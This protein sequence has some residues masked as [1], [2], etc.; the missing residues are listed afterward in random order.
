MP[1]RWMSSLLALA[2]LLASAGSDNAEQTAEENKQAPAAD[3]PKQ[4]EPPDR[5]EVERLVRRLGS[6]SFADREEVMKELRRL[7]KPALEAL[8]NAAAASDDKEVRRRAAD[9]LTQLLEPPYEK[10]YKEGVRLLEKKDYRKAVT[11]L[12]QAAEM[13]ENDPTIPRATQGRS[14]QPFLAEIYLRLARAYRGLE[15]YE[16]AGR[17]YHGA[18][19]NYN[20]EKREQIERECKAMIDTL[21]AEWEKGVTAKIAKDAS[22]KAVVGKY[23]LV[24][25]HTR[26]FA[27]GNYFKSAY[28]FVYETSDE[29]KHFNNV[30]I[31]FDNGPGN[32]TFNI[33]MTTDQRN[34]VVDLGEIDFTK[35]P[36][37]KKVDPDSDN[38]WMPSRCKVV[39]GHIYLERVRD[40][41]G[42]KFY[43]V[44]KV[45]AAD[46]D[47]RYMAFVWRRLPGG[48][49]VK[50]Q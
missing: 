10:R 26:R 33:N 8:R 28:S 25:L 11:E 7:G 39:E 18:L 21:L 6:D 17:A 13:Y 20:D 23:P 37:P 2:L 40:D 12:K 22:L 49:V 15:E 32:N 46:K 31:L 16:E 42:N 44:L 30:H 43:V 1:L 29:S 14:D 50:R 4:S 9:L 48:K 41:S 47:S 5:A 19:Y 3:K 34:L 27:G 38:F 36:D 24:I 45:I 35:D